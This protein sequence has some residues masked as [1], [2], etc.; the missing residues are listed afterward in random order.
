MKTL[1]IILLATFS[2]S[3]SAQSA[4]NDPLYPDQSPLSDSSNFKIIQNVLVWQKIYTTTQNKSTII[5]NI[6][7]NGLLKNIE[8]IDSTTI[9][10]RIEGLNADYSGAGFSRGT[11]PM[12]LLGETISAPVI[13]NIKQGRYRVTIKSIMLTTSMTTPLSEVGESEPLETYVLKKKKT[14]F[15]PA[16]FTAVAPILTHTFDKIFAPAAPTDDN[17]NW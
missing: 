5:K 7:T 14:Q 6:K 17:D 10:A 9:K 11:T 12:M 3:A 16:F 13:I 8:I 15:K 2:L 4:N 1:L